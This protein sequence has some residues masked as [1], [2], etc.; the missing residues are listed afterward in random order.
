MKNMYFS[1]SY[2]LWG[3]VHCASPITRAHPCLTA[4]DSWLWMPPIG[5][6][7]I[8][9]NLVS[10]TDGR[11]TNY[12]PERPLNGQKRTVQYVYKRDWFTVTIQKIRKSNQIK[13]EKIMELQT[14][15][16]NSLVPQTK[17][18]TI[19]HRN[20]AKY[21]CNIHQYSRHSKL[22]KVIITKWSTNRNS[23]MQQAPLLW[24]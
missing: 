8:S 19:H 13:P 21:T 23:G 10:E 22:W 14:F 12:C 18:W 16:D 3:S 9:P 1:Y 11:M 24:S 5:R 15:H 6:L 7:K 2:A 4:R 17:W 20:E